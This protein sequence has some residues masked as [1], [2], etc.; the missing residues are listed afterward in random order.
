MRT[1]SPDA[2]DIRVS[3]ADLPI[4]SAVAT[5]VLA[6]LGEGDPDIKDMERLVRL[7]PGLTSR[8]LRLANSPI[9]GGKVEFKSIEQAM[10]RLGISA[11]K[12]TVLIAATGEV[13]DGKDVFARNLWDHSIA[14]AVA[15]QTIAER[16]DNVLPEEAFVAGMLHDIGKLIIYGQAQK[17]YAALETE[18]REQGRR[19]FEFER[20]NIQYCT[21]ETIGSLVGRKWHLSSDMLE[22]MRFHHVVEEDESIAQRA[23]PIVIVV[24]AANL[25]TNQLGMGTEQPELINVLESIPARQLGLDEQAIEELTETLPEIIADQKSAFQE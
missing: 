16:I 25:F 21:H 7:D 12:Q 6:L 8:I 9:Y 20:E 18:A 2:M 11:L 19:F 3:D 24:S 14:T 5:R 10:V 15:S 4:L 13:F 23:S 17:E 22:V 1:I